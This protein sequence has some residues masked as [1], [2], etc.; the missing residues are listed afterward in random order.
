MPV[1][2]TDIVCR[3]I[4]ASD[5]S[6]R[7]QRPKPGA[8]KQAELSVWHQGCLSQRTVDLEE[9]CIEQLSG[10]GQ[11]HHKV[12]DYLKFAQMASC[13]ENTPFEI[14]VEWRPED[15]Y[16]EPPWRQWRE[17]HVQVEAIKGPSK[18]LVEFRRRL[19]LNSRHLIA[20]K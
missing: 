3:F 9:L 15:R 16:V 17:A 1:P 10:C 14:Q 11:S 8:F 6:R 20:P 2:A 4:R 12:A 19:A 5:W 18:F 13:Q 7:D